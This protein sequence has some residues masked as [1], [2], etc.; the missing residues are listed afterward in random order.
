M[1]HVLDQI[2]YLL[3]L[4]YGLKYFF[5]ELQPGVFQALQ[6]PRLNHIILY[7]KDSHILNTDKEKCIL[8]VL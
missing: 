6:V 3:N 2:C 1:L 5:L 8:L 4:R 7:T